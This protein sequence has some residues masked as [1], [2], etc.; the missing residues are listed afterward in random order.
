MDA[1]TKNQAAS[2]AAGEEPVI[3]FEP[4]CPVR[5]AEKTEIL[6]SIG[7]ISP[8]FNSM[9]TTFAAFADLLRTE[10]WKVLRGHYRSRRQ[11]H[12]ALQ[13]ARILAGWEAFAELAVHNHWGVEVNCEGRFVPGVCLRRLEGA[14]ADFLHLLPIKV[15]PSY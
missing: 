9:H 14:T 15:S 7:F 11:D 2:C 10:D 1:W 5:F 3:A 6:E 4:L 12:S 8:I 13:C